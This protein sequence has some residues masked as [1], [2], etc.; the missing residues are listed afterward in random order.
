MPRE[1]Q[2][3]AMHAKII[4][5]K[6]H[7]LLIW[8][9]RSG[10]SIIVPNLISAAAFERVGSYYHTFPRL[11]QA[12][13]S[14]WEGR[15]SEGQRFIDYF[16]RELIEN[17]NNTEMKILFKNGS[18]YRLLG[19]DS[20]NYDHLRGANPLGVIFDEYAEQN[21]IARDI[22]MPILAENGG[23]E[24]IASTPRGKNHLYKLYNDVKDNEQWHC[25]ILTI[26]DT[27][28][29]DGSPVVEKQI[30][31]DLIDKSGWSQDKVDQEFYC[32]FDAAASGAYFSKELS[33][34]R[35]SGRIKSFP[36]D[37][38]KP[39]YTVWDLGYRDATAIWFVQRFHDGDVCI[40]YY[41]NRGEDIPH[42]INYL[43]D[44]RDKNGIVYKDHFAPHDGA[45]HSLLTGKTLIDSC[46]ELGLR[47]KLLPRPSS[48]L[49]AI[50]QARFAMRKIT[51]H[52]A[53]CSRGLECLADYHPKFNEAMGVFSNTPEHNWSS[54]GAESFY[55]IPMAFDMLDSSSQLKIIKN[56]VGKGE[57]W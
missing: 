4:D 51:F 7:I 48:K 10:K 30:V 2:F 26:D 28:R 36:I 5:G 44:F 31:R 41:E 14:I 27:K 55:Y 12:R 52:E 1:H 23:W 34:C 11:N 18:I 9:R 21:P 42:Y 16:P 20:N 47:F 49:S 43:N 40:N 22:V 45:Q 19:T 46:A 15:T 33:L 56:A 57:L 25:E 35:K 8:H 38:R 29:S 54:H 39:V 6:K 53:N 3:R 13:R 50:E 32:S 37:N 24:M 17:V